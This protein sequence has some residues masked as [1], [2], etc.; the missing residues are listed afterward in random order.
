M[1]VGPRT[2]TMSVYERSVR[3]EA[4]LSAVWK[5]HSTPVGL[6]ALTP[7]WVNA[8][9][10]AVR[11]PDDD[12]AYPDG[13]ATPPTLVEGSELDL[14]T[15]PIGVGPRRRF[16]SRIVER[17]RGDGTARFVDD[18]VDGPFAHWEHTHSFSADG[19]ATLLRDHV[20]Y[21]LPGGRVG[22]AV[23]PLAVVGFAPMFRYRHRRTRALLED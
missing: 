3:V 9:V 8:R 12:T 6:T 2:P 11:L 20:E 22:G 18:M 17:R 10:E 21:R 4:P 13:D 1:P 19:D 15:R 14:S 7:D 5:F 16:T 23:S